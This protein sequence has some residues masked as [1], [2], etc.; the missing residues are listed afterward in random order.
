MKAVVE[1]RAQVNV[2]PLRSAA[3]VN[4]AMVCAVEV[5]TE[6]AIV[7]SGAVGLQSGATVWSIVQR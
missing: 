6:A 1:S 7:L 2:E 5:G 3:S 4:V